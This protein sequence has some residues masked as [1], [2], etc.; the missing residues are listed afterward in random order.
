M[1]AEILDWQH[2]DYYYQSRQPGTF[3]HARVARYV[4]FRNRFR[5]AE[6]PCAILW[7]KACQQNHAGIHAHSA[8][9]SQW[10]KYAEY[11]ELSKCPFIIWPLG[12]RCK[13]PRQIVWYKQKPVQWAT[14]PTAKDIGVP[15]NAWNPSR[16]YSIQKTTAGLVSAL[17]ADVLC[18]ITLTKKPIG[19]PLSLLSAR[20]VSIWSMWGHGRGRTMFKGQHLEALNRV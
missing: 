11:E 6:K 7:C 10:N 8:A 4:R 12:S 13:A 20:S 9:A 16:A 15:I 19:I 2:K 1:S 3:A 17:L 5:L 18:E 14:K